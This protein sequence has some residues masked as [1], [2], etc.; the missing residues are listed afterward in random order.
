MALINIA[1]KFGDEYFCFEI[2]FS[3]I[4]FVKNFFKHFFPKIFLSNLIFQNFF[5][6]F[7]FSTFF[8][9]NFLFQLFVKIFFLK[10]LLSMPPRLQRQNGLY[11]SV[12]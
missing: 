4:F 8:S 11:V 1:I 6:K 12:L 2:Y 7:F 10:A 5:S 3:K 9:Q